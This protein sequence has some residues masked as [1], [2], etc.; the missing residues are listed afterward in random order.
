VIWDRSR[1]W[2]I[3]RQEVGRG[4]VHV[5][6]DAPLSLEQIVAIRRVFPEFS[7]ARPDEIR[8]RVS[9]AGDLAIGEYG[10]I[11][12]RK[13]WRLALDA[14]LPAV[15]TNETHVVTTIIDE[16]GP[17][18]LLIEDKDEHEQTVQEML[19]AGVRVIHTASD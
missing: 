11:E 4:R 8:A 13:V 15:F 10:Y 17:T 5:Q 19:A 2:V 6:L 12:A 18:A 16:D 7:S 3:E 9:P 14:G 1:S